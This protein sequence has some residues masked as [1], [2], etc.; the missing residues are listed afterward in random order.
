MY[1]SASGYVGIGRVLSEW[2]RKIHEGN[3]RLLYTKEIYEYRI[4]V[5]WF[6]DRRQHPLKVEHGLP[7]QRGGSWHKIDE[8]R[9]PAVLL[10]SQN[11]PIQTL[12]EYEKN[13][14]NSVEKSLLDSDDRR[15]IRLT[16]APTK[17]ETSAAI[18]TIY[19]RNPDVVAEV[20]K[21]ANGICELCNSLAPFTRKSDGSPYLEVH[22]KLP[23]AMR[24]LDTEKNALALCPNC[25]RKEHFGQ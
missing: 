23:L 21:R 9:F 4:P 24:G 12:D 17:P 2:D 15:R 5:C 13:L 16:Q 1:H 22:H 20:L 7:Q 10:Y 11:Y 14:N 8:K 3:N 18:V 19:K 6:S 25:H